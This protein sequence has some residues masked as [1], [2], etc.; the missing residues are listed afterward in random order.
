MSLLNA[1]LQARLDSLEAN[2]KEHNTLHDKYE[3]HYLEHPPEAI[4]ELMDRLA[5]VAAAIRTEVTGVA[6]AI[7]KPETDGAVAAL[8]N[9]P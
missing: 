7:V 3:A 4:A 1:A 9:N 2:L 5:K 6:D 8:M